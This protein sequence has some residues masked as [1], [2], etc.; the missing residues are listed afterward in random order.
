MLSDY[1]NILGE[2]GESGDGE[3]EGRTG[4][5]KGSRE[6]ESEGPTG[7]RQG[8]KGPSEAGSQAE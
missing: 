7:R 3:K 1:T 8:G 6:G 4:G 5:R 2:V